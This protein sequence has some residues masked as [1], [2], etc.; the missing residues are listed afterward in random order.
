MLLSLIRIN[1]SPNETTG[2]LLIGGKPFC[3]TLEP[4]TVPNATHPKGAIPLGWYKLT[5][6]RSSKFGRVLP[7]VNYVPG[8][9]GIRIHAGNNKDHTAGCILVGRLSGNTLLHSRQTEQ[10]L[11]A[12]LQKHPEHENYIEITSG[13]SCL[14]APRCAVRRRVTTP[15][16]PTTSNVTASICMTVSSSIYML[17]RS[18]WRN[19][20]LVG[21]TARPS[22]QTLLP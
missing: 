22:R 15:A 16:S 2:I 7:L 14:P 6:T 10:D 13:C 21:V 18:I 20:T 11:I 19:G 1:E 12:K 4:P 9:E 8:F 5:L 17:T 3:G